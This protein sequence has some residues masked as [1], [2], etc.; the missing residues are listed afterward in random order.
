MRTRTRPIDAAR[1]KV[2]AILRHAAATAILALMLAS[3]GSRPSQPAYDAAI[4]EGQSAAQELLDQGASAVTIALVDGKHIIWSQAFGL[5]D[6]E[7][8]RA[9]TD[10]TMFGTGSVSKMFA[11]IAVMKLVDR[12]VVDLDT[13]LVTYLPDFRMASAGY[14]DVTVR[15]LLDHASG[16]PGTDYRNAIIRSPD[17]G[18]LDQVL[19]TLSIS[20]LKAPPGYMSVYCNDGFTV[21]AALVEA[22]TGT[23]YVQFV[24][25]EILTPLAMAS[26]RYPLG[27][28]PAGSYARA[29]ANG[30]VKPQEF[31]NTLAA[32]ALYSTADDLARV[33]IMFLGAGAVGE[34]RILSPAAVAEMAV[35]QTT[36]SF[37]PVR[38]DSF[39]YGLGW[40]TVVQPGLSAVGFDGWAKGGDSDDYG[41]ALVVSPQAQLGIVVIAASFGGSARALAIAERVLLRAL[42][43]TGRIAAFPSPLPPVV[44]P[45]APVPDGLL[46]TIAGEYAQG[47]LV[48]QLRAQPDGSL[49][50][51]VRSDAGWT[52]SGFPLK[53]RDDGW[54]ASDQDPL[55]AFKVV[56]TDLLGEPTR[57]MLARA[58]AGYGHYLDSSVF[59]QRVRRRPGDL[60]AAWRDRLSSTW[61][62]VNAHPDELEWNG[63]DPRLRLATVPDLDGLIAVRPPAD[64]PA[65]AAGQIDTRLHLVDPSASDTAATMMLIVP[66]LNGRDLDDLDIEQRDGA[67]WARFGS[68]LHQPLASVPV[69]PR[70]GTDLFSIG[71]AGHAEWRALASDATA[72]EVTITTTGAW[73]LYDPTFTS[74]ASGGGS[75][76]ASLPAGSGLGYLTLFGDPGQTITVAVR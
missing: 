43:E 41:A 60:S 47:P 68:Y 2:G 32:G 31:V 28:F 17:P 27:A 37:N 7:A 58:P 73:H 59:A 51:A 1:A 18:Y 30:A 66:Q 49:Q 46:A 12:G 56:D 11:A 45:V 40:D 54:F 29:Y 15:M 4:R 21:V 39:A 6:R 26:T 13:P 10:A 71:P 34:T 52:P 5:A 74:L 76:A 24:Q 50:A 62:V 42:D 75:A 35:D 14:E 55:K 9:P 53:Y 63:M 44:L 72:V 16:F 48:V 61:L 57:Y 3:C 20:R 25:D 38:N 70:G 65:P 33:A 22:A 8:G 67:Q 64:V 36:G 69:L 19:Q 23:S